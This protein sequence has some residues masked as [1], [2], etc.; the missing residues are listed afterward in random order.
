MDR[1]P[2]GRTDL[3]VPRLAIGT[4]THGWNHHSEQTAL[5]LEGL[6][7]LL[8]RGHRLGVSFWDAAD[9]YGSHPHVALALRQVSRDEVVIATKTTSKRGR[10]V[11]KDV[12]RFLKELGTDVLDIVLL[13]GLSAWDWP[14]RYGGAMGALTKAKEAGKVRAVGFSCHGLGALRAAV[15]DDWSDVLLVRINHAGVNM[16]GTVSEVVPVLE[17]LYA[18]GKGLY[19]MKV[20]G[21]GRLAGDMRSALRYV[22]ELGVVHS[23]SIGTSSQGQLTENAALM[24]TLAPQ[25]PLKAVP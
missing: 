25:Y 18:A 5:G 8:V 10:Q 9:Q 4:G 17:D 19:A 20:A 13:H 3:V 6:S 24:E 7:D 11:T 12:D 21:C 23:L 1:V 16:D 15:Q 2:F 14:R 22:L